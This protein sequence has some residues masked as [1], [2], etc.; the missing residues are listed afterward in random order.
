MEHRFFEFIEQDKAEQRREAESRRHC[1]EVLNHCDINVRKS[2]LDP[3]VF[4]EIVGADFGAGK[5]HFHKLYAEEDGCVSLP[6]VAETIESFGSASLVVVERAHLATAQTEQSLAHP[7]TAEQLLDIYWR[8]AAAGVT[9]KLFPHHHTRKARDWSARMC[10]NVESGKSSDINDARG[11]AYYVRYNNGIAL[12]NPPASFS[13][14]RQRD[15]GQAVRKQSNR[16]LNAARSRGYKGEVFPVVADLAWS[17]FNACATPDSF[18][19]YKVA[20][21]IASLVATE[22]DGRPV[23]FTYESRTPGADFFL[24]RVMLFTSVHHRGGVSRSNLFWHRFRPWLSRFAK[25]FGESTKTGNK[26]DKFSEFRQSQDHVR[27]EGWRVVR[28]EV[29]DAYRT[30]VRLSSD[31]AAHEVLEQELQVPY[32]R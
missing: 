28:R 3:R 11:L 30:A 24:K 13:R 6:K 29:R 23:R 19:D 4:T 8:C 9:L 25:S 15:Y 1:C 5:M 20:F 22:I 7:F 2:W 12:C 21:S 32:G 14:S 16:V 18:L 27:R 10:S 26:Y 31:L 17:V